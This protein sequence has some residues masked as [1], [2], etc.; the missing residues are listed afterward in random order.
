MSEEF[1][2]KANFAS[3]L[4]VCACFAI[5]INIQVDRLNLEDYEVL[6]EGVQEKGEYIP[7]PKLH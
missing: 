7:K 4:F 3:M 5:S 2:R 6:Q 1:N